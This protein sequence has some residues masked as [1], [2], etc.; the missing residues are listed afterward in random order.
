[1]GWKRTV[2]ADHD[3]T[4]IADGATSHIVKLPKAVISAIHLRLSGTGGATSVAVDDM[5]ATLK[6]KTEK[7]YIVDLRSADAHALARKICG[8]HPTVTN[9]DG[10]YSE[11]TQ[12]LYFGRKPRDRT[13]MLN[14]LD[15]NVRFIELTFETLIDA[16]AFA[17]GTVRLTVTI[18]EWIGA[19][20]DECKGF[21]ATKEVEDKATGT[22]KTVFELFA[23]KTMAL[24]VV[25]S[26][27]TTVRQLT[28]SD[29]KESIVFGKVNFRDLLN[30]DN[31]EADK[32]TAETLV[33]QW[34][35]YDKQKDLV[36]IPDLTKLS[37]PILALERGATTT[38]SRVVQQYLL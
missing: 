16:A 25:I 20:P 12:S 4:N 32:E 34:Q 21:V 9:S 5:I 28:L 37:D 38:T 11:T 22:G 30:I 1:M 29:K 31:M 2:L 7:G 23:E 10:A 15:S 6:V 35:F 18:E 19:L 24:L 27:I 17:T 14:L 26:A 36:S 8:T 13:L 33:A 3:Q